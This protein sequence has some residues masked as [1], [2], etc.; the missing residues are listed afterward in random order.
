MSR[1]VVATAAVLMVFRSVIA[2]AQAPAPAASNGIRVDVRGLRNS[3][4]GVNCYLFGSA[5]GFPGDLGKAVKRVVAPIAGTG[6]TCKFDAVPPGAYAVAVVHDEKGTGKLERNIVG[7]PTN[8]VGVSNDAPA[9]FGP[10]SFANARFAYAGGEK[11]L[12]VHV[13]YLL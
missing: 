11:N 9:H 5:D 2:E 10:P 1:T 6:A 7:I 3:R 12:V 13:R 4:G 8:G